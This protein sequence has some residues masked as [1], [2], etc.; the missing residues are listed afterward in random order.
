MPEIHIRKGMPGV[1]LTREQFS[2][3]MQQQFSD[4]AFSDIRADVERIINAAW[5]GYS[6]YRKAPHTQPAGPGYADPNYQL[7]VDWSE[8]SRRVKEAE[9]TQKDPASPSRILL[10]NG[11]ARS[12]HSC[13]GETSKTWR[14]TAP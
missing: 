1:A 13:P 9:L 11:S 7:S 8:A 5:Q 2:Q 6:E 4:P 12:E 10:I 14:L 3:R